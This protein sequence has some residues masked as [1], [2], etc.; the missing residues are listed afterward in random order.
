MRAGTLAVLAAVTGLT[1]T[2]AGTK[3]AATATKAT[4]ATGFVARAEQMAM[5]IMPQ[6]KFNEAAGLF[7]P[8]SKKYLPV[9]RQFEREYKAAPEKLPVIAKYMPQAESALA[10]ARAMKVPARYE[11][12]KAEYLKMVDGFMAVLRMTMRFAKPKSGQ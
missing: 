7:G 9:F 5:S 12:K 6:E 4:T 1:L 2:A 11:A 8:V 10:E 3:T